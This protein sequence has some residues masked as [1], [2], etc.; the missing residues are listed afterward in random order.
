MTR[1]LSFA[2]DAQADLV[3]I[4]EYTFTTW[5]RRQAEAYVLGLED[6]LINLETNT[7]ALRPIPER[8]GMFRFAYQSHQVIL[9]LSPDKAKVLRILHERMDI[10]RHI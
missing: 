2:P 8:A 9:R 6:Q 1:H 10:L 5:G 7:L 3:G 4:Y